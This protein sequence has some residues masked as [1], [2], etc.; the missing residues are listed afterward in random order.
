MIVTTCVLNSLTKHV[1]KFQ[2]SSALPTSASERPKRS[3]RAFIFPARTLVSTATIRLDHISGDGELLELPFAS[4]D[5]GCV[6]CAID[7]PIAPGDE[8]L[9]I[10]S[11]QVPERLDAADWSVRAD[12]VRPNGESVLDE[13]TATLHVKADAVVVE[14]ISATLGDGA[15]VITRRFM[16]KSRVPLPMKV[17]TLCL[18]PSFTLLDSEAVGPDEGIDAGTERTFTEHYRLD[19]SA[20]SLAGLKGVLAAAAPWI[21]NDRII[22]TVDADATGF[23]DVACAVV[24]TVLNASEI[25][26]LE[27]TGAA[28]GDDDGCGLNDQPAG[29]A[30]LRSGF[31]DLR[32]STDL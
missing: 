15:L 9:V 30:R 7:H 19:G 22:A 17:S 11:V 23:A 4:D 31:A 24:D 3:P 25:R 14:S 20:L 27:V 32:G 26:V 12:L 21:A 16:N 29:R 5:D 18:P 13:V 8:A 28:L 10:L 6:R 1:G 2:S